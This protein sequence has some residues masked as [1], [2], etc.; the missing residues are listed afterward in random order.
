MEI[1]MWRDAIVLTAGI[2]GQRDVILHV[3][4]AIPVV[5]PDAGQAIAFG[6]VAGVFRR[7]VDG[8][9]PH[10]ALVDVGPGMIHAVVVEPEERLHLLGIVTRGI[11]EIEVIDPLL[12]PV[13]IWIVMRI[14][15]ALRRRMAI[16][17]VGEERQVRRP[18]VLAIE[19]QRILVQVVFEAD[20]AGLPVLGVD[21][22][23][24]E[25]SVETVDGAGRQTP[26]AADAVRRRYRDTKT[27]DGLHQRRGELMFPHL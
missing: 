9:E 2:E 25:G 1:L 27:V 19:V 24:R 7:I 11:V 6:L 13:G 21:P 12:G 20:Q 23:S 17:Q 5:G 14:A 26:G 22:G 3:E 10:H 16:V 4:A 18:E 15:V 8:V